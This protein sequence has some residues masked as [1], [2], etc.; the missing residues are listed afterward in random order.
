MGR[1][2]VALATTVALVQIASPAAATSV[3]GGV[4]LNGYEARLVQLV[5]DARAQNSLP[6]VTATAG[7]TDVARGWA[8]AQASADHM[9]HNPLFASQLAAAGG[10]NW[11]WAAENVGFGNAADP[12]QLFNLYMNSPLHRANILNPRAK[13]VGMGVVPKQVDSWLMAYNTMNFNDA[14]TSSYGPTRTPAAPLPMDGDVQPATTYVATFERGIDQRIG[15]VAS[16][17]MAT[18]LARNDSPGPGDGAVRWTVHSAS[19]RAAGYADLQLRQ[20]MELSTVSTMTVRLQ[21]DTR[22]VAQVPVTIL[23]ARY[24]GATVTVG[25]AVVTRY[26]GDYT[27]TLPDAARDYRDMLIVRVPATSVIH[28][29]PAK[30]DI[31][32]RLSLYA[33]RVL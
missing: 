5:N 24:G 17:H 16:G 18:S 3:V 25:K 32:V 7:A 6:P 1:A 2:L 31:A 30:P 26:R 9:S 12:D 29:A 33:V 10:R 27:F 28:I 4:R 22:G 19:A 14:Y 21:V 15:V 23:V 8:W 11:T 20:A 13:F